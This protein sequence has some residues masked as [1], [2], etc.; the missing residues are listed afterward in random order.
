[1]QA[2]VT[3]IEF[4]SWQS[5]LSVCFHDDHL[6]DFPF[7][8]SVRIRRLHLWATLSSNLDEMLSHLL[9]HKS[10]SPFKYSNWSKCYRIFGI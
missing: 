9:N 1:M 3:T 10:G 4:C 5:R 7:L 2:V 6:I 8:T